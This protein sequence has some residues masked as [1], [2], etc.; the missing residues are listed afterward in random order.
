M[1]I[2]E[3]PKGV[4]RD[5]DSRCG[6]T[7]PQLRPNCGSSEMELADRPPIATSRNISELF[8]RMLPLILIVPHI[9]PRMHRRL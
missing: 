8:A 5:Y 2:D 4:S 7:D 1:S 9:G 6:F 3:K